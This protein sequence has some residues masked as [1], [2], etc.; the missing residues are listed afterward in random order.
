MSLRSV[1]LFTAELLCSWF[2]CNHA[3]V[4]IIQVP[5]DTWEL[6]S[7]YTPYIQQWK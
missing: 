6:A 5:W 7:L 4:G 1:D 2:K 3:V